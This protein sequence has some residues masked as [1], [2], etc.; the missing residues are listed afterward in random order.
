M[1]QRGID[2]KGHALLMGNIRLHI[3]G[4]LI[5]SGLLID[6]LLDGLTNIHHGIVD[7]A[8][9]FLGIKLR[10]GFHQTNISLAH[11]IFHRNALAFIL[12]SNSYHKPKIGLNKFRQGFSI[13]LQD[14]L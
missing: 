7:K 1:A 5:E 6:E 8:H 14:P 12:T 2:R 9:A 3:L 11:D 10:G 4:H 13:A